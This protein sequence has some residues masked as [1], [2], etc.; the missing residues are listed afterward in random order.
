M[1][2]Q[3]ILFIIAAAYLAIFSFIIIGTGGEFL[4]ILDEAKLLFPALSGFIVAVG[5][6]TWRFI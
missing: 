6:I 3:D 2:I 1:N 4:E 5:I